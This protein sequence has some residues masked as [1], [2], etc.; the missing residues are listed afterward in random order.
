MNEY[1]ICP[2][3]SGTVSSGDAALSWI[4]WAVGCRKADILK[5]VTKKNDL[6]AGLSAEKPAKYET[7]DLR[8]DNSLILY[9]YR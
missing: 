8:L 5:Y 1:V 7:L 4:H 6:A 2:P 3:R 9:P